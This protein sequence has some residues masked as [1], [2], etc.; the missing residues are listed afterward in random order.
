MGWGQ[1]WVL[2]QGS[3]PSGIRVKVRLR[4]MIWDQILGRGLMLG[5]VS[6]QD[7]GQGRV[8]GWELRLG[9][10]TRVGFQEHGQSRGRFLG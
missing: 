2:G 9:F 7:D 8:L 1:N 6:S 10:G 5:W 4:D 3:R